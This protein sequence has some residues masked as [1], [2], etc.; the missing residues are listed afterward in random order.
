MAPQHVVLLYNFATCTC[1]QGRVAAGPDLGRVDI[2][3]C[4]LCG[5]PTELSAVPM[6]GWRD[7]TLLVTAVSLQ[8]N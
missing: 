7:T 4:V 6:F 5:R 1:Q 3:L 2:H 8:R